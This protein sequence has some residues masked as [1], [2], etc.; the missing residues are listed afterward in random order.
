[1][2]DATVLHVLTQAVIMVLLLSGPILIT[3]LVV[4]FTVALLQTIT[5][6]QEQTLSFV[7]KAAAVFGVLILLGPWLLSTM[8]GFLSSLWSS[9]PQMLGR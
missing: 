6:I 2:S 3:S 5:S 4:G 9:I 8:T 1:M 7:P